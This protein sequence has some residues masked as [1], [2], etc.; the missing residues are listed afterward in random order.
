MFHTR[1]S[2]L[3]DA[4]IAADIATLRTILASGRIN[5]HLMDWDTEDEMKAYLADYE[6]ERETR[7]EAAEYETPVSV[8]R[9]A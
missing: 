3:T 7:A 8:R 6:E 2:D 4:E 9:A 1:I 5:G